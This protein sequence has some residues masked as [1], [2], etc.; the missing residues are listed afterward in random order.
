MGGHG[1]EPDPSRASRPGHPGRLLRGHPPR[2]LAPAPAHGLDPRV[3]PGGEGTARL[4]HR[5]RLHGRQLRSPRGH[6]DDLDERQVR[7][8]RQPLL[9]GGRHPRHA[10]PRPLHD[11]DLQG[12]PGAQRP[13]V[14]Q[15]PLRRGDAHLQ[16]RL[17]RGP[18]DPRLRDQPLRDGDPLRRGPGLEL[19]LLDLG[20]GGHRP[21]LRR[22]RGPRGHDLQRGPP[23]LPHRRGL[24]PPLHLR[25]QGPRGLGRTA[26]PPRRVHGPHLAGPARRRPR[27]GD[28]G[29]RRHRPR[30]GLRPQLRLLVHGLPPHPARAGRQGHRLR[31]PHPT[32]GRRPQA[33]LPPPRGGSRP[34]RRRPLSGRAR[35]P[36]RPGPPRAAPALLWPR[37]PRPRGHGDDGELH[38]RH[39]R[40][41][42]RLQHRL[43]LRPL[44]EPRG[45][46][47]EATGTTS[48]SR[49]SPPWPPSSSRWGPPTSSCASTT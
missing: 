22:G 33:L 27:L 37:P 7:R 45:P 48:W 11:A 20:G 2:G 13:R 43:D 3:P 8:P 31:R 34:G 32:G 30:P 40:Q 36:L 35:R 38:V 39:G 42:H 15:A 16:R 10:L 41:R 23:V 21:P 25:P 1:V 47:D 26:R 17:L 49:R 19:H 24:P 46:R 4:G 29:R 18:D 9:L 14:P 28:H 12:E 6:G 5:P 44:P